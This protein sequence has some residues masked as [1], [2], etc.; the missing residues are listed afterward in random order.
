[1]SL[2]GV[3]D[4]VDIYRYIYRKKERKEEIVTGWDHQM[5]VV[6]IIRYAQDNCK[7]DTQ[8]RIVPDCNHVFMMSERCG[9]KV[10]K[11]GAGRS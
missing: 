4:V 2:G 5:K 10:M 3:T 11:R 6:G 1:V 7:L 9:V 8:L